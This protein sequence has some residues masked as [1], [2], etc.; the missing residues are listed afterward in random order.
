MYR[1]RPLKTQKSGRLLVIRYWLLGGDEHFLMQ[2]T[3]IE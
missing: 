2:I 1:N 3:N